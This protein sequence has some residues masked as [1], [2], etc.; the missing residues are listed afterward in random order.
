[1]INS[2]YQKMSDLKTIYKQ[3]DRDRKKRD[4]DAMKRAKRAAKLKKLAYN[5]SN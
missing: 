4:Y 1:M 2:N 5:V 3:A